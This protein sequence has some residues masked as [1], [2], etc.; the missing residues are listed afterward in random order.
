MREDGYEVG[1]RWKSG[2]VESSKGE[3]WGGGKVGRWRGWKVGRLGGGEVGRWG[4]WEVGRWRGGEMGRWGGGEVGRWE[5]GEVGRWCRD[6]G[7]KKGLVG[8]EGGSDIDG[9]VCG[10]KEK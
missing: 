6:G 5:S 1:G 2:E 3:R 8:G 4:G 10:R 9:R 7:M